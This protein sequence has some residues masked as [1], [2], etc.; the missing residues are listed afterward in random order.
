M[1]GAVPANSPNGGPSSK[2]V[3]ALD[4][5]AYFAEFCRIHEGDPVEYR[6]RLLFRDGWMYSST[7]YGGPEWRPPTDPLILRDL[8][9]WYWQ[10]RARKIR[11]ELLPLRQMLVDVEQMQIGRS[12]P[13]QQISIEYDDK[14]KPRTISGPIDVTGIKVRVDFLEFTLDECYLELDKLTTKT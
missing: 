6:G 14:G 11:Q 8:K 12:A 3:I 2:A 9:I 1:F 5:K 13:L 10:Q 7:D 4:W